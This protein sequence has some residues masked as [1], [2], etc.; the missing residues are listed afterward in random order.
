MFVGVICRC[1]VDFFVCGNRVLVL[2]MGFLVVLVV[3]NSRM[4]MNWEIL[5][6]WWLL[7]FCYNGVF[8]FV[9]LWVWIVE[10]LCCL[11]CGCDV[12]WLVVSCREWEG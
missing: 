11:I 4:L 9:E 6:L 5:V 2:V 3:G 8:G 1:W 10:L 7:S 12:C